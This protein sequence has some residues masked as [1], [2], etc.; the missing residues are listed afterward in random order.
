MNK[1]NTLAY[2]GMFLNILI[3]LFIGLSPEYATLFIMTLI[4]YIF[5]IIGLILIISNQI[6]I[7]SIIFYIASILFI[8]IGIIG[9]MG[10]QKKISN[11]E[12]SKFNKE[13]YGK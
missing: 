13:N 2:V 4:A 5:C 1:I 10:I 12:E 3:L 9:I 7:G 11:I 8:P 6:K